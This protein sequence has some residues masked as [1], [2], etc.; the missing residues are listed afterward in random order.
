M[1]SGH[2][3]GRLLSFLSKLV[4]PNRIL[5]LGTYTGYSALCLAEGLS[6]K[7]TITTIE[8]NEELVWL[9]QKYWKLSPYYESIQPIVGDALKIIPT[10]KDRFDLVFIDAKKAHYNEYLDAVIPK[11]S[12]G[13]LV[14]S[15]N[16][17]WSGKV[18]EP[19]QRG[20]KATEALLEY[21]Q[22]LTEDERFEHLILPVRDGLSV[23]RYL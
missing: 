15:D 8:V 14:V 1:I 19:L 11:L 4:R 13:C 23:A 20:D 17:L 3:Q 7:G 16:I 22:R 6:A 10:L 2:Y 9:Q 21:N 18:A 12:K 5:E